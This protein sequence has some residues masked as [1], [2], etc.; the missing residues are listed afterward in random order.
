MSAALGLPIIGYVAELRKLP[1]PGEIYVSHNPRS[2]VA[3]AFRS[4]RANLELGD[5]EGPVRT[6]LVTSSRPAE[7]KT[8]IATNLAAIFAQSGKKVVLVDADMRR[9]SV[10]KM[11]RVHNR[12]D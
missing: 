7:G 10:H 9:P 11:T 5:R 4:L 8:T 3:E 12:W 6:I 1:K 2:P